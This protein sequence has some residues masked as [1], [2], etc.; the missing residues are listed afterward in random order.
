LRAPEGLGDVWAAGSLCE[1]VFVAPELVD[2]RAQALEEGTA[3]DDL[4]LTGL[5]LLVDVKDRRSERRPR[6]RLLRIAGP[7]DD[8]EPQ[9][10]TTRSK[11]ERVPV[12]KVEPHRV[13][14][15][16]V[17]PLLTQRAE[18]PSVLGA[19]QVD[20]SA[21]HRRIV[22]HHLIIERSSDPDQRLVAEAPGL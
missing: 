21:R 5:L 3:G 10:W 17:D 12:T 19:R 22:D 14:A 7:V 15:V 16:D 1:S 6:V 20:V 13:L 11:A 4:Y 8:E 18:G 9:P 2:G